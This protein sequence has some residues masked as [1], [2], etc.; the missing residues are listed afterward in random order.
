MLKVAA[1]QTSYSES[2]N[3]N[4]D[5]AKKLIRIAASEGANIILLSEL[6]QNI[7]FCSKQDSKWF[8]HA[9]SWENHPIKQEFEDLAQELNVVLPISFF[10]KKDNA[11]FNSIAIIDASGETIGVYRKSH[12]PQGPG[13]EEK[14]YF[15]PGDTG[16]KVWKTEFGII[17]VGIC[18]DQW[19]PEA[20]RIMTLLGAD[21]LLYPTAIGSEPEDKTLN[22]CDH[23]VTVQ[24]GH[25]GANMIPLIAANRVGVE[26]QKDVL[27]K[28]YGSSFIAGHRGEL[29]KQ[30]SDSNDEIIVAEFDIEK[31]KEDRASWGL[32]RDR[33]PELY[34]RIMEM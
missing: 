2:V 5:K 30:A 3:D 24:R 19:S 14:F 18:W 32:F 11:F 7:Y 16:F 8:N 29:V 13:Y 25:A 26:V 1:I 23:W 17:G 34:S 12:I 21:I 20:A 10:E 27:I 4:K 31:I 6:P 28:F 22:S 9:Y 15:S 33:R